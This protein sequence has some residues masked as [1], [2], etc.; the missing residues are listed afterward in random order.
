MAANEKVFTIL[1]VDDDEG[2]IELA[3]RN[4]RR[5]GVSNPI[6]T[7]HEGVQALNYLPAGRLRAAAMRCSS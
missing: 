7:M 1:M 4:L 2:H 6:V 5:I 3:R